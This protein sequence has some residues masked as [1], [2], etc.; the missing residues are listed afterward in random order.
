MQVFV[1]CCNLF[2]LF[3]KC[4]WFSKACP[5]Q[6]SDKVSKTYRITIHKKQINKEMDA[7]VIYAAIRH[8]TSYKWMGDGNMRCDIGVFFFCCSGHRFWIMYRITEPKIFSSLLSL[9][10]SVSFSLASKLYCNA[11]Y[12]QYEWRFVPKNGLVTR[13]SCV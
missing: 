7:I 11:M 9:S 3:Y 12:I 2:A 5:I 13:F 10:L 1:S 8:H 6:I 4:I